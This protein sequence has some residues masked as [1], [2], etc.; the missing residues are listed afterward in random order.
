MKDKWKKPYKSRA[1]KSQPVVTEKQVKAIVKKENAKINEPKQVDY[2][3][4]PIPASCFYHNVPSILDDNMVYSQQG[5]FDE[6]ISA[7]RNRIGDSIYCKY[8]DLTVMIT[9]FQ[10]RP[11]LCYRITV[12]QTRDSATAFPG[13]AAIYGHPQ[14]GNVIIAPVDTELPGLVR[15]VYDK[16]FYSLAYQNSS[17]GNV[18]KKFIWKHR[19][20]VNRK[21]QYDNA[22]SQA[23]SN[24]YKLYITCYDT[25]ASL[26]L[27]N[28]AR[29]SYMR[30]MVFLDN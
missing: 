22:S 28:V 17:T 18:D 6:E 15:V 23:S 20:N 26:I 25:Q 4:E 12:V 10:T 1:K 27:D 2:S 8:I 13:G 16:T 9:N 14:C 3:T 30:R 29:Y 5:T 7:G 21:I 24:S 11:N 19:I